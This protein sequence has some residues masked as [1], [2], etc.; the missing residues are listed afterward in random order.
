M[1][2]DEKY[3]VEYHQ[4]LSEDPKSEELKKYPKHPRELLLEN[5]FLPFVLTAI[6]ELK[7]GEIKYLLTP[8]MD[9]LVQ[10]FKLPR[11]G[12]DNLDFTRLTNE[13]YL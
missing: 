5:F 1:Y 7:C 13:Q 10:T 3:L 12:S 6:K 2:N 11:T 4:K 9:A 8:E